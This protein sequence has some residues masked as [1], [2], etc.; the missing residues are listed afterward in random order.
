[1][2]RLTKILGES[3]VGTRID[4]I[5]GRLW[6]QISPPSIVINGLTVRTQGR[7]REGRGGW[8]NLALQS[9]TVAADGRLQ[10]QFS[11]PLPFSNPIVSPIN[12]P[13]LA[14]VLVRLAQAGGNDAFTVPPETAGGNNRECRLSVAPHPA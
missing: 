7:P 6:C 2:E 8:Y 5:Q 13:V 10:L 11:N 1:M 4:V 3:R 9:A 12:T 14:R